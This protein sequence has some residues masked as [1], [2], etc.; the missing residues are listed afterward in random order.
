M[1]TSLPTNRQLRTKPTWQR[2]AGV[3]NKDLSI[4]RVSWR[5]CYNCLIV[6]SIKSLLCHCIRWSKFTASSIWTLCYWLLVDVLHRRHSNLQWQLDCLSDGVQT[7]I[8]LPN[9][10]RDAVPERYQVWYAI[11]HHLHNALQGKLKELLHLGIQTYSIL[12][13]L[14]SWCLYL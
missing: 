3:I 8:A 10:G 13:L 1:F 5:R 12:L 6:C 2:R 9:T 4:S 11:R 14:Y 7:D